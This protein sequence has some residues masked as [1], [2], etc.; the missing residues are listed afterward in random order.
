[1]KKY[2]IYILTIM[3]AATICP[4]CA[5]Q[6]RENQAV[7][8]AVMGN[9]EHFYPDYEA[10]IMQAISDLNDEY[11]DDGF[12]F[13]YTVCDD[14]GRYEEGAEIIENLNT[15]WGRVTFCSSF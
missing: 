12:T 9:Y 5:P 7:K 3:M 4:S 13:E 1:M 10:G 2:V 15:V 8:I 11:A 14:E 6:N